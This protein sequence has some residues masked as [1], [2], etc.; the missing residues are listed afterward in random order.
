MYKSIIKEIQFTPPTNININEEETSS[1][2]NNPRLTENLSIKESKKESYVFGD[3]ESDADVFDDVGY[4]ADVEKEKLKKK[5]PTLSRID[6]EVELFVGGYLYINKPQSML[7]NLVS[8][9]E[10]QLSVN[11]KT[12]FANIILKLGQPKGSTVNLC[13]DNSLENYSLER[14]AA[15][16]LNIIDLNIMP[17]NIHALLREVPLINIYNYAATFDDMVK[18]T[19]TSS[20]NINGDYQLL[21]K[22]LEDPYLVEYNASNNYKPL[23]EKYLQIP[24]DKQTGKPNNVYLSKPKLLED[25]SKA[26]TNPEKQ[27]IYNNKFFRNVLFLVNLQRVIRLKLKNAVYQINNNVVSDS[28][29]MNTRITEYVDDSATY[30][31]NEFEITDLI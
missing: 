2:Y 7:Y 20:T 14:Q 21:A 19:F 24:Q 28:N 3:F 23:V 11:A 13:Q 27:L 9:V 15:R 29:V 4:D 26:I 1:I 30:D 6:E 16:V 8:I 12:K 22:L 18:Q 25:I 17:I 31:E 10:N 5:S